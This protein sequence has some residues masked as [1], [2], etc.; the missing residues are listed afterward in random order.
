MCFQILTKTCQ[1]FSERPEVHSK[2]QGRRWGKP[3]CRAVS[4]YWWH[5]S[6]VQNDRRDAHGSVISTS[7]PSLQPSTSPTSIVNIN[8]SWKNNGKISQTSPSTA[9][10]NNKSTANSTVIIN[11][12]TKDNNSNGI[13]AIK[14]TVNTNKHR[15]HYHHHRRTNGKTKNED[16]LTV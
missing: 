6:K 10:T 9:F 1:L 16:A 14:D 12:T 3:F 11:K 15:H 4:V 13:T 2:Q 7:I 5:T 8:C